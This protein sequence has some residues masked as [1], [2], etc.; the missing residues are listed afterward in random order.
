MNARQRRLRRRAAS[1]AVLVALGVGLPAGAASA[2]Q[3][4]PGPTP[5]APGLGDRLFPTLGNGGYDARSYDLHLTYP[6]KDPAQTIVGDVTVRAVATQALSRFD[7]DFAGRSL[8]SVSV[9]G[10]P[11]SFTRHGSELVINPARAIAKGHRFTVV[12]RHFTARPQAPDP[13]TAPAGFFFSNVGTVVAAQ[14]DAAQQ[15]FPVNDHPRDKATYRFVID[16]PAGW[17]AATNG[18]LVSRRAKAG[19]VVWTFREPDPLASELVQVA[20]GDFVV[21][22]RRSVDGVPIRDVVPRTQATRLSP[23]LDVERSQIAWMTSRVGR[24]P[25]VNYGSLVFDAPIGYSLETQTLSL[26]DPRVFAAPTSVGSRNGTMLHEL[27]HEWFG[28]SVSPY[29]WS[30]IWLNEGHATWY[31]AQYDATH[32]YL[33]D[34]LGYP[35]LESYFKAVYRQGD[36]VRDEHGPVARPRSGAI[37]ELFNPNV[38]DGGALVLYALRQEIGTRAFTTLERRWVAKYRGRSASTD[39]F[40]ALASR[41]AGRDLRTFLIAWLYGT[42]TPPMPGHPD[43]TVDPVPSSARSSAIARAQLATTPHTERFVQLVRGYR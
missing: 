26:F 35:D 41:A 1:T 15:V 38:Y 7:L 43:W 6:R 8:G 42:R 37:E 21:L 10:R 13:D 5:G 18:L 23:L 14:P 2:G 34:D 4:S 31:E 17:T 9:D 33:K 20:V 29:A 32:G 25:T 36:Q 27:A 11:A 19:R 40:I 39:D 24:Y 30:D 3:G 28:D 22:R 12:V 16:A